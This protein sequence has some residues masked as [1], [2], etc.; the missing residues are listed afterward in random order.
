[1]ED[2]VNVLSVHLV[3]DVLVRALSTTSVLYIPR[4]QGVVLRIWGKT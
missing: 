3:G 2:E 4:A 1:M